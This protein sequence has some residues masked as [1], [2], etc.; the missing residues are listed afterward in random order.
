MASL[1]QRVITLSS[2]VRV[3]TTTRVS[4]TARAN[5]NGPKPRVYPKPDVWWFI[6]QRFQTG[7]LRLFRANEYLLGLVHLLYALC[8]VPDYGKV[9]TVSVR[10][11]L[12]TVKND[13][14]TCLLFLH[15][16][17]LIYKRQRNKN[18]PNYCNCDSID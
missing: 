15:L 1:P 8:S 10:W 9:K 5:S 7:T 2:G 3:S 14:F 11:K 13:F 17:I 6:W 16:F 18:E 12:W 4:P